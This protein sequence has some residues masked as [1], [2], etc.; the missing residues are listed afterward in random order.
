MYRTNKKSIADAEELA[1]QER[2]AKIKQDALQRIKERESQDMEGNRAAWEMIKK[3]RQFDLPPDMRGVPRVLRPEGE[4]PWQQV[5]GLPSGSQRVRDILLNK[6][7]QTL[8]NA[9]Q[10]YGP[11][12]PMEFDLSKMNADVS[13]GGLYRFFDRNK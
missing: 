11:N 3:D 6:E 13:L 8:E 10:G 12:Q 9:R 7:R 4:I 2:I 1:R 5:Q